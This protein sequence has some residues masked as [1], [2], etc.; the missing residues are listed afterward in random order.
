MPKF[1]EMIDENGWI[2]ICFRNKEF[3][4]STDRA[5]KRKLRRVICAIF[6]NLDYYEL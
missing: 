6:K 2:V 4:L 1:L 3:S 5:N